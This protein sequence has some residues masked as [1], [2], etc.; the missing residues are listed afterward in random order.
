MSPTDPAFRPG[1]R[2]HV[3]ADDPPGHVRTP[4]Y[5][6]G[7][8]GVV[9]HLHGAFRNPEELAYG[10]DGLPMRALYS[11]A[12]DQAAVWGE[13][14]PASLPDKLYVDIYEHWLERA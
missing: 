9:D 12:F 5:V 13:R 11:I 10:R 4:S 14:Y 2:V 6:R 1:D 7:K 8:T 3:R